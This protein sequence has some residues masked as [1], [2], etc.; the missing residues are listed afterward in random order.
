ML[1]INIYESK[2]NVSKLEK[3]TF[4]QLMSLC[5]NTELTELVEITHMLQMKHDC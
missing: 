3:L 5:C 1:H 4:Q 2:L